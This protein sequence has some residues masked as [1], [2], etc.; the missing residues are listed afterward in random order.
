MI[1]QNPNWS[2]DGSKIA[3]DVPNEGVIY[4]INIQN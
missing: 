1:A 3:F 2:P 4:V